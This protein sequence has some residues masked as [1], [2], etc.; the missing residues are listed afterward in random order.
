MPRGAGRYPL[1]DKPQVAVVTGSSSGV[2]RAI[3]H[4]FAKRGAHVGLLARGREG[5]DAAAREVQSL[6]G[7]ALAVPTDVSDHD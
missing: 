1:V 6:G 4:A 2:G 7:E 5:L 3:A